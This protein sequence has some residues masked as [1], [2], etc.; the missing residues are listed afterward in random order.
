MLSRSPHATDV[1]LEEEARIVL[2]LQ[3]QSYYRLNKTGSILWSAFDTEPE[4][5]T[6][7]LADYLQENLSGEVSRARVET[8]VKAFVDSMT[9]KGLLVRSASDS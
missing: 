4:W 3:T 2:H 8:D 5:S 6:A 9:E 1:P 7:D